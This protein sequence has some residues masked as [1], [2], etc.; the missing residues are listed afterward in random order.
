[1]ATTRW[2]K[3]LSALIGNQTAAEAAKISGISASNFTRWKK[4]ARADPEFVVKIAR[5]YGANVLEAL[6]AAEFITEEEAALTEVAPKLDLSYATPN[7]LFAEI[8]S[9]IDVLRYL[10]S[11]DNA[12]KRE[13][14]IESIVSELA[15]RRA[16][17]TQ[18]KDTTTPVKPDLHA[19]KEKNGIPYT[20]DGEPDYDAIVDGINA[21]TEKFAAQRVTEPLEEHWT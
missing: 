13:I 21:G 4:G 17:D 2:W 9:R 19:V 6:T 8:L 1:M 7:E 16:E 12:P 5:A 14:T 3:Y 10:N 11:L 18:P 20:D 15:A